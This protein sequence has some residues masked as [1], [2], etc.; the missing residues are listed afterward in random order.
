MDKHRYFRE[1]DTGIL[2]IKK[3]LECLVSN[4]YE[5]NGTRE[6]VIGR[7]SYPDDAIADFSKPLD[8]S[9]KD[10]NAI[11]DG[12]L[13]VS[14]QFEKRSDYT[15]YEKNEDEDNIYV[16]EPEDFINGLVKETQ[17]KLRKKRKTRKKRGSLSSS[18][19]PASV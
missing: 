17:K 5:F 16:G 15:N 10:G 19:M 14:I 2:E 8:F 18:N 12:S 11:N 4:G 3:L 9:D 13:K 1:A 7:Y 6:A